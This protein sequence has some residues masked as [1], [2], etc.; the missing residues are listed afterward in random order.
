MT[1][2]TGIDSARAWLMAALAFVTCFVIFGVVYSFGAFFKPMAAEFGASRANTSAV[3][4]I[5]AF[6]YNL[7]GI[8][9][10]HLTD[11]MGPRPVMMVG[12]VAM[13]IGLVATALISHIWVG[14]LTY[15]IGV[16]IG[17]ACTY[18][19]VLAAVG[20][21]FKSRRNTALG[22][23]VSGI[24]CGTLAVAPLAAALIQ[25]FGWREAYVMMGIASAII[26]FTIA[27]LIQPPPVPTVS[28]HLNLA[29]A[30]RTPN[31]ILLWAASVLASVAIYFPFVYLPEFAHSRG[32]SEVAA[33]ALVGFVGAASIAGRLGLGAIADR[34]G[35]IHLYK[36][37]ALILGASY[38]IWIFAG[39]YA[40]MVLFAIVMGSAYGGMVAL[41][42][43]VVA[44]LFGVQGLGA[45]L[46]ALY[47]SSA[48]SALGGPPLAGWVIDSTGSYQWAAVFAGAAGLAGFLILLPIRSENATS[49]QVVGE[50]RLV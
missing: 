25:R 47:T 23:T 1:E 42:P 8:A 49:R 36:A 38:I 46:G 32:A 44:E 35:I 29:R 9:G 11:R 28:G 41:S 31:F 3:F 16:G 24:G 37:S 10:G 19:P 6:I 27:L 15:G 50:E 22:I 4:S 34:T 17:V 26:L 12:A 33:A 43:A 14:Y 7:L 5:T 39:S 48:I 13:G 45:M 30:A 40:A 20:G 2:Y 18:V 21:W